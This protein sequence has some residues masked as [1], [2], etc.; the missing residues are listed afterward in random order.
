[1]IPSDFPAAVFRSKVFDKTNHILLTAA[2]NS[3]L[4][5]KPNS[6]ATL[7]SLTIQI[8]AADTLQL[9]DLSGVP[10]SNP[11]RVAANSIWSVAPRLVTNNS[12]IILKIAGAATA[13]VEI[14]W[15]NGNRL[16]SIYNFKNDFSGIN[17]SGGTVI[18]NPLPVTGDWLTNAE[19]NSDFPLPVDVTSSVPLD[20]D[21]TAS[22]LPTNAAQETGGNLAAIKA[23]ADT[24]AS[25]VSGGKEQANVAQIAGTPTSVNSGVPDAGS[26]RVA[27]ANNGNVISVAPPSAGTN[28]S[29]TFTKKCRIVSLTIRFDTSSTSGSRN[30][31]LLFT[32]G[33]NRFYEVQSIANQPANSEYDYV[34]SSLPVIDTTPVGGNN[35]VKM[36]IPA[37]L[38]MQSG[39]MIVTGGVLTGDSYSFINIGVVEE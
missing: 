28:W 17:A 31:L 14:I 38:L 37:G 5:F 34:L 1:M 13:N 32:D 12:G 30:P 29:Y 39:W 35:I 2:G 23:D 24:L 10:L 11:Y 33:T 15:A 4:I 25:A 18:P 19:L 27:V 16:D 9:L 6:I 36:P 8:S 7:L 3:T 26:Q 22:A 21:V 20:V